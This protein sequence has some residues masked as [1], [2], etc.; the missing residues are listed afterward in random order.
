[1]SLSNEYEKLLNIIDE[2]KR[3][4]NKNIKKDNTIND[5]PKKEFKTNN[6]FDDYKQLN[7]NDYVTKSSN[8]SSSKNTEFD[9]DKFKSKLRKKLVSNYYNVRSYE[10]P[11]ISV[12]EILSCIRKCYYERMKYNVDENKLFS[13]PQLYI[14]NEVGNKVHDI[15][16]SEY[17]FDE[18]EKVL[19]SEKYKL[20]GRIDA[21]KNNTAFEIK[22]IDPKEYPIN[23]IRQKDYDQGIIYCYILN[24]EY[25]YNINSLEVIY[26]SRNLKDIQVLKTKIDFKRAE[27]LMDKSIELNKCL[28][29]SKPPLYDKPA[30]DE[31]KYCHFKKYCGN[32]K[33]KVNKEQKEDKKHV[34]TFM[35]G[36]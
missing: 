18:T 36:D 32:D 6:S 13:F 4:K 30:E 22:T 25:G 10:R 28:R 33:S 11:Y 1:M 21:I 7:I 12:T 15:L 35:L 34:N 9:I 31:C 16:Q 24:N 14:I 5:K 8:S 29:L 26:I 27:K 20:K 19:K 23:N 3:N 17:D 2:E